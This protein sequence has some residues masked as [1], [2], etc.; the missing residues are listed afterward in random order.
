VRQPSR[1][2]NA[3]ISHA[4][5]GS[6]CHSAA[7]GSRPVSERHRG[8]G[9]AGRA[10]DPVH[11][12]RAAVQLC[13]E[14]HLDVTEQREDRQGRGERDDPGLAMGRTLPVISDR[15]AWAAT[16]RAAAIIAIATTR[17]AARSARAGRPAPRSPS[18][19]RHTSA[20]NADPAITESSRRPAAPPIR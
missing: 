1:K 11:A 14:T 5:A 16:Y 2:K 17:A 19:N 10:E 7:S 9:S 20:A 12:Q 8:K 4:A 3:A 13:R 15:A 6:A 18:R